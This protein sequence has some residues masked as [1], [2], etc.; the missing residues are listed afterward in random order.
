MTNQDSL[1]KEEAIKA[2]IYVHSFLA[3]AGEYNK[4]PHFRPENQEKVR[5]ILL[6]L[7]ENV[8]ERTNT[9][10]I[11]FGCGTGFMIHL[12]RD[13]FAEVHGVDITHD[14]MKQVDLSSGNIHLHESLA[15]NTPFE[16]GTFDFAT[17][18]SFMDHLFNYKDFLSEAYRVLKPG[19]IFYSDLNPN[20]DFILAIGNVEQVSNQQMNISPIVA[21]EVQGA[22]HNG[23]Y[24]EQH[25]GMDGNLLEK[26]EPIKSLDKGFNGLEVIT[27]AHEIGFTQCNVEYEWFLGQA[28]VMHE[29]SREDSD[30]V[31]KYLNSVLPVS[32]HLFKYL[33]FVFIK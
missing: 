23:E 25:F 9:K 17:A 1:T 24:Y 6:R 13:L 15:E 8:R 18:Y 5:G 11:D 4:S 3:N 30:I 26:A 27:A 32:S 12:M 28:K 2:N 20:R 10:A 19:G 16:S 22:L 31:E 21:R 7:T 14:M 33:R 29:Q